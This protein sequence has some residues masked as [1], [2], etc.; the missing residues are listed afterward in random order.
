MAPKAPLIDPRTPGEIARQTQDLLANYLGGLGYPGWNAGADGGEA[1]RA[2]VGV[3]AHYCGVIV[4]RV[5]RAPE[6]NFLAFLDLL[7]NSPVPP[8]PAQVPV[9]FF[10]DT[11]A[12]EGLAVPAGTRIQA[13]S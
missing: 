9:T 6:K 7:G 12:T 2:L 1:G 4:D 8:I 3:F 11:T 10:L 5:N 13:E